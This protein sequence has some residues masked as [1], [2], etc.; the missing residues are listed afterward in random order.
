MRG[1]QRR[2]HQM[3]IGHY[4]HHHVIHQRI[5]VAHNAHVTS[6]PER[7]SVTELSEVQR[8]VRLQEFQT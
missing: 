3:F 6:M 1:R 5:V 4:Q 2:S 8:L 7:E